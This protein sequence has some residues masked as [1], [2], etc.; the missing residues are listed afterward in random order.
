MSKRTFIFCDSCNPQGIRTDNRGY[1]YSRR[2]CDSW[3]WYE[4]DETSSLK[5]G[6]ELTDEGKNVC[7][8]CQR[9]KM[10]VGDQIVYQ[11]DHSIRQFV[12]L[13]RKVQII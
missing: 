7:P 8:K 11:K 1:L 6:W 3:S 12:D 4:G 10:G 5:T 2:A 9:K 13:V